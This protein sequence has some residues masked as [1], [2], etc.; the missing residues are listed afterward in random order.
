MNARR[1]AGQRHC[2]A[3]Q[4]F[5]FLPIRTNRQRSIRQRSWLLSLERLTQSLELAKH[6]REVEIQAEGLR[7]GSADHHRQ[8]KVAEWRTPEAQHH[9]WT[10][11]QSVFAIC[12]TRYIRPALSQSSHKVVT[13]LPSA[14]KQDASGKRG[15]M[16]H[17][18]GLEA[19]TRKARL[20]SERAH[21]KCV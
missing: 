20:R 11:C 21:G 17:T 18:H 1:N 9:L 10:P 7:G 12:V 19:V 16:Q 4:E 13:A 8:N 3:L 15:Y 6:R 2:Y 14:A 5:V